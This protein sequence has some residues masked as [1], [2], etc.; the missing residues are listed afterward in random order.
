MNTL[1][2]MRLSSSAVLWVGLAFSAVAQQPACIDDELLELRITQACAKLRESGALVSCAT[3]LGQSA[4][5]TF[6]QPRTVEQV[7]ALEPVR[8]YER[9][10][11]SIRI[12]GHYYLCTEC[13]EWHFA[14]ASGFCVGSNGI[15]ATCAH[16]IAPD[17]T[18]REAYLVTAD[19][20]GHV[21]AVESVLSKDEG[22]DVAVLKTGEANCIPLALRGSAQIGERVYCLSNP[23]HQFGYFS[24]GLVARWF[25]QRDPVP[26]GTA[27]KPPDQ[28]APR[29]WLHVTCDFAKG[30]SG[31]PIVDS[32]GNVVGIAQSTSTVV[33]DE[34]AAVAETQMVFKTATPAMALMALLP[35]P[36]ADV[37]PTGK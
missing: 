4:V 20:D 7:Q 2:P 30:S 17:A 33:Y 25:L 5:K 24:E 15:V 27:A 12:V 16:V 37:V 32:K 9:V 26:E 11:R 36:K 19:L 23:D 13:D 28:V 22:A 10:H 1:S 3:L 29:T 21:W 8:V 18:M 14:G 6:S 31:A 35:E 34:N